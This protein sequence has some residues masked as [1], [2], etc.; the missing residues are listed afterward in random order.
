LAVPQGPSLVNANDYHLPQFAMTPYS[1]SDDA[2]RQA[3]TTAAA[4]AAR[5]ARRIQNEN[6]SQ[7]FA[8]PRYSMSGVRQW[9]E[10]EAAHGRLQA[11]VDSDVSKV[12]SAS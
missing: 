2:R 8:L 9:L 6:R 5:E 1:M 10:H 4:M 3:S 7:P 12:D 11:N